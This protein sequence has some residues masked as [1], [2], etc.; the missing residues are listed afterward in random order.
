MPAAC[1]T[2]TS[3]G[4]VAA[5]RASSPATWSRS[6]VSQAVS[7]VSTPSVPAAASSAASS[8]TPGATGPDREVRTIRGAPRPVSQ[9]ATCPPIA[10]VPPVISTVPPGTQACP[11]RGGGACSSRR[12]S[13]PPAVMATW[14]SPHPARTPPSRAAA[15]SSRTGGTSTRPPQRSGC[16]SAATRPMPHAIACTGFTCM[17]SVPTAPQVSTHSD[18]LTPASPRAWISACVP[19]SPAGTAG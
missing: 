2:A 13:R 14:S 3:G 1:M 4:P 12:T 11:A 9:R 18:A 19:A 10:P 17:S 6:A 5:I 15:C 16:S 7:S 8:A